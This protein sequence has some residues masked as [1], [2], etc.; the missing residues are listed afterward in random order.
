MMEGFKRDPVRERML[1]VSQSTGVHQSLGLL[2]D[3]EET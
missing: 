2:R 1:A 3:L